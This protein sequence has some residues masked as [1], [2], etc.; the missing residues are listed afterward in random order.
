MYLSLPNIVYH[1]FVYV[2]VHSVYWCCRSDMSYFLSAVNSIR[3]DLG[4][5]DDQADKMSCRYSIIL[6]VVFCVVVST[7]QYVGDPIDCWVCRDLIITN[8]L[9]S[10]F[11]SLGVISFFSNGRQLRLRFA[12]ISGRTQQALHTKQRYFIGIVC[13]VVKIGSKCPEIQ[14]SVNCQ[15]CSAGN[16]IA[17]H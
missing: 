11:F 14:M 10:C 12:T 15:L 17:L 4:G 8:Y 2:I 9:E 7:K 5:D 1:I 3:F 13:E 6:L 16:T